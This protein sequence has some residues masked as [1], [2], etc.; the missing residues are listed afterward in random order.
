MKKSTAYYTA[1]DALIE[2]APDRDRETIIE[3]LQVL[4]NNRNTALWVEQRQEQG[5]RES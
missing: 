3:S 5:K 1:I 2:V 4:C